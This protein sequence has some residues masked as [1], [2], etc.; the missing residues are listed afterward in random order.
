MESIF[1]FLVITFSLFIN[2]IVWGKPE[3]FMKFLK[4]G[5][6]KEDKKS[7]YQKQIWNFIESPNYIWYVRFVS[8]AIFSGTVYFIVDYFQLV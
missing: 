4:K 8:L 7:E 3:L 6:L 1:I 2:F 5:Q